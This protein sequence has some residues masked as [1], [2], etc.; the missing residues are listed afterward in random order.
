MTDF[1]PVT[2]EQLRMNT[3]FPLAISQH[4]EITEMDKLRG[5]PF[6]L[7]AAI[8]HSS[9][10]NLKSIIAAPFIDK[11]L[12][13]LPHFQNDQI[14]QSIIFILISL[15]YDMDDANNMIINKCG[16]HENSKLVEEVL[17]HL[18]NNGKDQYLEKC[19]QF[20]IDCFTNKNIC[21][22]FYYVNDVEAMVDIILSHL[23]RVFAPILS[24]K[25]LLLIENILLWEKFSGHKLED[26]KE[27][28]KEI[29]FSCQDEYTNVIAQ[30]LF[31][32]LNAL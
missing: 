1:V 15:S 4:I 5:D 11:L 13:S 20:A 21:D 24:Q 22:I 26:I 2:I 27:T 9:T 17:Q 7:L 3:D 29:L 6:I 28:M 16:T 31:D 25:L 32:M 12:T 23:G 8:F 10:L 19:L 30:R 18:I 14:L